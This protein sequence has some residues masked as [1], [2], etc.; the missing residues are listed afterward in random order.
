MGKN[1]TKTKQKYLKP[2]LVE[3]NSKILSY[4]RCAAGGV[5]YGNCSGSGIVAGNQCTATGGLA[6]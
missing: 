4:G 1:T 5:D 6:K 3:L 2:E